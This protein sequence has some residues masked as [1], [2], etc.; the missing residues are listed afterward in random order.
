VEDG[1]CLEKEPCLCILKHAL[2]QAVHPE[3]PHPV[4]PFPPEGVHRQL[5]GV[6]VVLFLRR[7]RRGGRAVAE[8]RVRR[9]DLEHHQRL[10]HRACLRQRGE[11][12]L[13][14]DTRT[15]AIEESVAQ[16][17]EVLAAKQN[18]SASPAG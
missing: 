12:L 13:V 8:R 3:T 18:A 9:A 16:L 7:G 6:V 17:L 11:A 14:Q 15:Q 10:Q 5:V 4:V 2:E 1:L